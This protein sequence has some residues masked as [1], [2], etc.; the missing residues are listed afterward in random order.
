MRKDLKYWMWLSSIP[1]IGASKFHRLVE[2]FQSPEKLW[3]ARQ[4]EYGRIKGLDA[5]TAHKILAREYKDKISIYFDRIKKYNI[6]VFTVKDE[7]YPSNLL[8]IYDPPPVLYVRGRLIREDENAVAIVGSR[9]ATPYGLHMARKIAGELARQGITVVSGMARGIDS[10]AHSGALAAGGRTIAV[11]GCGVDTV[12]PPENRELMDKIIENGAVVSEFVPGEPPKKLNF[13]ARN[14]IISGLSRGVVVAEAGKKSGALITAD[15]ALEQGR[16]VFALP[17]DNNG[18]VS[19]GT[20]AL[21]DDGAKPVAGAEDILEELGWE[22]NTA[23]RRPTCSSAS[24][25][26]EIC[27]VNAEKRTAELAENEKRVLSSILTRPKHID[28]IVAECGYDAG[29]VGF[30]LTMLE[31]KGMIR[32]L[33][34]AV[35]IVDS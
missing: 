29:T 33:P 19:A 8:S 24:S 5:G 31:L 6:N 12:Y 28:D 26:K 34:G 23:C 18:S 4:I 17:G 7:G 25:G 3:N 9:K 14:R 10:A 22:M 32:Q 1:G 15:F 11:L 27:A 2:H 20:N 16:E 13:P 21:I 30:I 35:F